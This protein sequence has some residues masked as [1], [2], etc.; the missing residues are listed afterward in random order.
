LVCLGEKSLFL[1]YDDVIRA[2]EPPA[3]IMS[4]DGA[5]LGKWVKTKDGKW[6]TVP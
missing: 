4:D 2:D 5:L 1:H 6:R 3:N